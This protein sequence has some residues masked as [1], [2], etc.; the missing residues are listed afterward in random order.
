[1][2]PKSKR[3]KAQKD[4]DKNYEAK[5]ATSPRFGGRC[6]PEQKAQLTRLKEQH[7][8]DEKSLIFK[9][10]DFFDENYKG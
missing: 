5:R 6:T 10:V 8:L 2:M 3:T 1:M 9:A 7:Q 4:A